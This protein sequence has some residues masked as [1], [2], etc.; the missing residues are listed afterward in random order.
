MALTQ[1]KLERISDLYTD[2]IVVNE[3][4]KA[5]STRGMTWSLSAVDKDGDVPNSI[6]VP[7]LLVSGVLDTMQTSI[8]DKLRAM[9]AIAVQYYNRK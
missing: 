7:K 1:K 2:L 9:G 3:M 5:V 4:L 8:Y 6:D